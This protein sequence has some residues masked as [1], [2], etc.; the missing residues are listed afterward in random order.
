MLNHL[1]SSNR[2]FNQADA[3]QTD[4]TSLKERVEVYQEVFVSFETVGRFHNSM[5]KQRANIYDFKN[6]YD[7]AVFMYFENRR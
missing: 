7:M 3:T 2:W 1:S 6:N 5:I 4:Y